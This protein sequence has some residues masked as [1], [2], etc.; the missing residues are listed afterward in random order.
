M[1]EQQALERRVIERLRRIIRKCELA[2]AAAHC[3]NHVHPDRR[4]LDVEDFRVDAANA[5]AA[6]AAIVNQDG[7]ALRVAL[8][9]IDRSV[10]QHGEPS[11][12]G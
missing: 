6:L 3:W 11:D 4:P 9:R 1:T 7:P 8:D 2:I 12:E 5:K 10:D